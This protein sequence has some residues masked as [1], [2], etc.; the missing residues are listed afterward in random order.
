[1]LNEEEL[2]KKKKH[3]KKNSGTEE[4]VCFVNGAAFGNF[5]KVPSENVCQVKNL[6]Y[7]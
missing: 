2:E 3:D 5:D 7:D 1:M 6:W 4:Q